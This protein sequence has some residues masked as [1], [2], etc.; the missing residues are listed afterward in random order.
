MPAVGQISVI[1]TILIH[2]TLIRRSSDAFR[3]INHASVEI[4]AFASDPL[5]DSSR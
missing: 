3:N 5:V 1:G 4:A 2:A